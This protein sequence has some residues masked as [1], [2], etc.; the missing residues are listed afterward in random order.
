M[1]HV[2]VT[3]E[4]LAGNGNH[5][6]LHQGVEK[7]VEFPVHQRSQSS[8]GST[9]KESLKRDR[10]TDSMCR[11]PSPSGRG[12]LQPLQALGQFCGLIAVVCE[13]EAV[14][15]DNLFW[16][17]LHKAVRRKRSLQLVDL[18]LDLL[19]FFFEPEPLRFEI[20][21]TC[22]GNFQS[23]AARHCLCGEFVS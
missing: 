15:F 16:G 22:K 6:V 9:R 17:A 14:L 21:Q 20:D 5:H 1:R 19:H 4:L 18:S 2:E 13:P 7:L 12:L 8:T 11:I 10:S 23:E 3:S